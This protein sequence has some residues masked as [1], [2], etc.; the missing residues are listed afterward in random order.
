MDQL[1]LC[2]MDSWATLRMV[3]QKI[4][5][6]QGWVGGT[7]NQTMLNPTDTKKAINISPIKP[8]EAKEKIKD[9]YCYNDEVAPSGRLFFQRKGIE[10]HPR[11]KPAEQKKPLFYI[12]PDQ[13]QSENDAKAVLVMGFAT[14]ILDQDHTLSNTGL[15]DAASRND[16]SKANQWEFETLEFINISDEAKP[17]RQDLSCEPFKSGSTSLELDE[18]QEMVANLNKKAALGRR[19][20]RGNMIKR[21]GNHQNRTQEYMEESIRSRYDREVPL[22]QAAMVRFAERLRARSI[23]VIWFASGKHDIVRM[24]KECKMWAEPIPQDIANAQTELGNYF[25]GAGNNF[26]I[27]LSNN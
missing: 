24:V 4:G 22:T 19:N 5:N 14:V 8:A 7:D 2:K 20:R 23:K 25:Y 17:A 13:F 18:L 9:G 10:Y 3:L 16:G 21:M 11:T 26:T 12:E 15:N 6:S 1:Y 27:S